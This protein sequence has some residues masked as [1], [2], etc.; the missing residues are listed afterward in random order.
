MSTGG[1]SGKPRRRW[2]RDATACCV[3]GCTEALSPGVTALQKYALRHRLC[4]MHLRGDAVDT[5]EGPSR[6]CQARRGR[7]RRAETPP[8][9]PVSRSARPSASP[10][11]APRARAQKCTRLQPLA[12][13]EARAAPRRAA[14]RGAQALHPARALTCLRTPPR[15][16]P[17]RARSAPARAR[18]ARTT[19]ASAH[20]GSAAPR[21]GPAAAPRRPATAATRRR[22]AAQRAQQQQPPTC[23]PAPGQQSRRRRLPPPQA[24]TRT[25]MRTLC[26]TSSRCS[27]S[28]QSASCGPSALRVRLRAR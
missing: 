24:S 22:T 11:R 18:C 13:F 12:E 23:R 25:W 20:A 5:G 8:A 4:L 14:R 28:Q 3:P 6:F 7:A 17:R 26:A 2:A 1:G 10:R 16:A 15:P 27:R 9:A 19:R 21:A